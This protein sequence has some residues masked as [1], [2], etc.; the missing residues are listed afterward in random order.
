MQQQRE[1]ITAHA[2]HGVVS[3]YTGQQARGHFLQHPVAGGMAQR[4]I[5]RFETVEIEE[6]Q[7]HPG[8]L[9][10]CL[11]QRRMQAI[12]KQC[13]VGQVRQRVVIS[14]AV[15]AVLTGLALA[16][17]AEEAHITGQV[18]FVI[19][20]CR[21]ADPGRIV[22]AVASLEPDFTF[23]GALPVQLPEDVAQV[24]FL[25]A[26]NGEHARQLVEHLSD[27]V[28]ADAREGLVGLHDIACGVGDED[29]RGGMLK[30][31]GSHAQVF[32]GAAL[33]ADVPADA[34]NA[35]EIAVF[36]P[37]QYHAQFHRD[38]ATVCTQAVEQK[39]PGG[40]FVAQPRQLLR[41]V[42]DFADAADERIKTGQL[43]GVGNGGRPAV[44][45]N[46]VG[47]VAQRA[48]DRGADV[49]DGQMG[50]GGKD[51]VADAFGEHTVA[52]FAVAQRLAGRNL[53]GDVLGN[54]DDA[55][56]KM[57]CVP[58][59]CLLAHVEATP[60]VLVIAKAQHA[61]QQLVVPVVALAQAHVLIALGIV[62]V[63][64]YFP[65]ELAHRAQF[66]LVVA[67]R[68]A[69]MVVAVDHALAEHVL[70]IQ[71]VR[72]GADHIGPEAFAVQQ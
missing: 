7:H 66:E 35:L 37:Y 48:L 11:L 19:D 33:L 51:H 72:H 14:Q 39:H 5:D 60:V 43:L 57:F 49:I 59:Q 38:L 61:L 26:F 44:P 68:M 40:H 31:C 15:D 41:L 58:G 4:V 20:H 25:F 34:E 1:F 28:A 63:Q 65:E 16:D 27:F 23:P 22:F 12:L 52:L 10:L 50:V 8:L 29:G 71:V 45:G 13:A 53:L 69:K 56:D 24:R 70:H 67:Q 55:R 18:A 62:R 54:A 30:Y 42:E 6:H 2:C 17:V 36:I 3:G 46:P 64:Q 32:F 47:A 9:A 21:D